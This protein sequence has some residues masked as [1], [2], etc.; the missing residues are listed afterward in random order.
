MA[1]LVFTK[2]VGYQEHVGEYGVHWNFFHTL[3][4]VGVLTAAAPVPAAA[5]GTLGVLVLAGH[6]AHLSMFG[7]S[8]WL[9]SPERD[10][11]S[12]VSLNKEGIFSA[13]GY[14]AMHL[15]GAQAGAWL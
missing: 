14:W 5:R 10:P 9:L 1:R 11:S 13:P 15:I 7:G 2:G 3:A 6:Q 8:E 12:L 4:A